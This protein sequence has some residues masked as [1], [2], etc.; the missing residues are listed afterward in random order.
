MSLEHQASTRLQ[1][2]LSGRYIPDQKF[3]GCHR[4]FQ[5]RLQRRGTE[6]EIEPSSM[7][8]VREFHW[9]DSFP[10]HIWLAHCLGGKDSS[11]I[12]LNEGG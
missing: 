1:V 2:D 5:V 12:Y 10:R 8:L 7:V 4:S 11:P 9:H 6:S 3:R